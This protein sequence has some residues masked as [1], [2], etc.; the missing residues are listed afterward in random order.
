MN[1]KSPSLISGSIYMAD[2]M[3][4]PERNRGPCEINES[5]VAEAGTRTDREARRRRAVALRRMP[6]TWDRKIRGN[7]CERPAETRADESRTLRT[8]CPALHT[9]PGLPAI[10]DGLPCFSSLGRNLP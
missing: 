6:G 8:P 1:R 5:S 10:L 9:R 7:Q 2:A 3:C 4:L